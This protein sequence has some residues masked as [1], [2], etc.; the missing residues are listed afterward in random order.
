[1]YE[2]RGTVLEASFGN[3]ARGVHQQLRG[4]RNGDWMA[5]IYVRKTRKNCFAMIFTFIQAHCSYHLV[6][7]TVIH[8][9]FKD[10]RVIQSQPA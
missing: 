5:E 8:R 4:I 3:A 2:I 6:P 7:I 10:F 9:L 1:M